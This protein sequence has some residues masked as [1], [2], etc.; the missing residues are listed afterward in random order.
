MIKVPNNRTEPFLI[1]VDQPLLGLLLAR[2]VTSCDADFGRYRG[3]SGLW[4]AER[5]EDLWVHGLGTPLPLDRTT[6][7]DDAPE[8]GKQPRET[9]SINLHNLVHGLSPNAK[10]G[11]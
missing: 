3:N 11:A 8:H 2:S 7:T 5:P 1:D 4:P 9:C 10:Y 6:D